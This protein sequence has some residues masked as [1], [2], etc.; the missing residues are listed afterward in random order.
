[1]RTVGA[2]NLAQIAPRAFDLAVA[3]GP[4]TTHSTPT[5]RRNG[6]WQDPSNE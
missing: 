3:A 2:R 1:M 5:Q 6:R 4:G